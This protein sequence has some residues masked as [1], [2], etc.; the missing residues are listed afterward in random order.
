[1]IDD[2]PGESR[3]RR[4]IKRDAGAPATVV[5]LATAGNGRLELVRDGVVVGAGAAGAVVTLRYPA[6][7]PSFTPRYPIGWWPADSGD[8]SHEW[9]A[10]T[11]RRDLR[12]DGVTWRRGV[13][14]RSLD[15]DGTAAAWLDD[16]EIDFAQ[17]DLTIAAW[18]HTTS[19]GTVFAVAPRDG[20]W[21]PDG[22]TLF[23]RAGRLSFDVGWVGV[24]TAGPRLDDGR[25]HHV[26]A[27]WAHADGRVRLYVD[28]E[29]V[30]S[31]L[32]P[33]KNADRDGFVP[34]FGWT[35][36]DF[37]A[38]PRFSGY[39]DG[40][41]LLRAVVDEADIHA[42]AAMTGEPLVTA[43]VVRG[44]GDAGDE[45]ATIALAG[46]DAARQARL[47]L[48]A[49][50]AE[51]VH[52]VEERHGPRS[53][54]LAWA[55]AAL[56]GD[57][58]RGRPFR[59]D[60]LTWPAD[61]RY[62][63]WLRFGA[64]DF[65]PASAASPTSAVITT[66]S[67]DVWRVDGLD[68]DL[69]SLRWS[70]VATGLNQ[71]FG[72]VAQGNGTLVL[73]RD[74]IT[75]LHDRN[76]D[77]EAD[78]YEC[79]TNAARNS[80][81]FHEPA[82]GLL[83]TPDGDYL[84]HKAARHA[85]RALHDHHG[86]VLRVSA[87]GSTTEVVAR[88]FRAPIGLTRL[89]DGALLGSDQ[90]GHWTPAN[91]INLIRPSAVSPPFYGNGWAA[92]PAGSPR[93]ERSGES[94]RSA[95]DGDDPYVPPLC[96]L[97]P[98]FDRSPSSQV[99]VDHPAWGPLAGSILGLSYGTGEVYL[100][101]RDDVAIADGSTVAQGGVVKLGIQLPTGLLAGRIH[102][103]SGDLYVCGLFGWS[104]DRTEPGGFY[105]VRPMAASWSRSLNIP[106]RVRA[107]RDGLELTFLH[108]LDPASATNP[109]GWAVTAWN[110]RRNASYGS[111]TF[112]LE[113]R[114][115][116]RTTWN[117]ANAT[118]A[119]DDRTVRLRL[120]GFEP[121]MQVHVTWSIDDASG[122][123]LEHETQLTVHTL[124]AP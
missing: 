58:A 17:D 70:R 91:R 103:A 83:V 48:P 99:Y 109:D 65:V 53:A 121:A 78:F 57:D 100:V 2:R 60:R 51:S 44:R 54:V 21:A 6:A 25:W 29:D 11:E 75:R 22:V 119:D 89:P 80:E 16:V 101:L 81:H 114:R 88:G 1:M 76:H 39:M 36:R 55:H 4:R 61:N 5:T 122:R 9:N 23:L 105:R 110:Y 112:D 96:W 116:A 37:P 111:P 30:G 62:G 71:P 85:K 40:P 31:K 47:H 24:L 120:D 92:T 97:H 3:D 38:T 13:R 74:Q 56:A 59:I 34:R 49:A 33:L 45:P 8:G 73:G 28:G 69:D 93:V 63:S 90:E 113:G 66:W 35:N 106:R 123:R 10:F 118:L 20:I 52:T 68:D 12:L 124:P 95:W 27:T 46:A 104:S 82:S 50:T 94:V 43:T 107:T 84:Y 98:T 19:D 14:G 86:T 79:F 18:I 41:M 87:D 26:A 108:P 32:L 67:G 115:D 7:T 117:V 72:V 42:I 77:G 15:F 102:P 64:F